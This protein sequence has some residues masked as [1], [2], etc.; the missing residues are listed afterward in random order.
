MK[1]KQ[2]RMIMWTLGGSSILTSGVKA[3]SIIRILLAE[4]LHKKLKVT[5][6]QGHLTMKASTGDVFLIVSQRHKIR[7][8]MVL[9]FQHTAVRPLARIFKTAA[10]ALATGN[11]DQLILP[12][13][14]RHT[15]IGSWNDMILHL[16]RLTGHTSRIAQKRMITGQ[17][18]TSKQRDN[19]S[20]QKHK[21]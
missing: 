14:I 5:L 6:S 11:L 17:L 8:I 13:R 18:T 9:Q 3:D 15:R 1:S 2:N 4:A 19:H 16:T 20:N 10:N 12:V 21:Q 7:R